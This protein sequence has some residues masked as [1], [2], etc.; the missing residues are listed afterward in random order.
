MSLSTMPNANYLFN[1]NMSTSTT[2]PAGM[3]SSLA[4]FN[5]ILQLSFKSS[6]T[7]HIIPTESK[8]SCSS[9]LAYSQAKK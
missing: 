2:L 9:F 3:A 1:H 6:A 8:S 4:I 5:P 7:P